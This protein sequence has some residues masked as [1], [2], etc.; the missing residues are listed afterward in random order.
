MA[1]G[2]DLDIIEPGSDFGHAGAWA[3]DVGAAIP[4]IMWMPSVDRVSAAGLKPGELRLWLGAPN[5]P[6][7]KMVA[8]SSAL[9]SSEEVARA[10]LFRHE[11]DACAFLAAHAAL[12]LLLAG[13]LECRTADLRFGVGPNGKPYLAGVT[14]R[15][16]VPLIHFNLSHSR[17]R[18]LLG[19]STFPVGV[20]V[21]PIV[22]IPDLME[23][24]RLT[25][26]PGAVGAITA[27]DD[28]KRTKLFYRFWTLAEAFVKATGLGVNQVLDT[29][30]FSAT[31]EPIL[32]RVN[33][34]WGPPSRWRFGLFGGE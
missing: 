18:V 6:A 14:D 34:D 19:L 30:A 24:A 9:L 25:F 23:I 17:S 2:A 32:E 31:G 22:A 15:S 12:R 11:A 10:A 33:H 26:A 28:E 20:D 5:A 16:D 4:E 8:K 27:A 3:L 13:A 21:E 1:G 7:A 29:F